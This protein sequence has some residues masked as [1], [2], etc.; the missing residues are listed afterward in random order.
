M[1][2]DRKKLQLLGYASG[3]AGADSGSS[4]GPFV[5]KESSYFSICKNNG[6][7]L[8]WLE[9]LQP[10]SGLSKV[11][12]VEQLCSKLAASTANLVKDNQFFTAFGGDHS[13]AIGTWGGAALALRNQGQLGL[14]W[15]DAHMDSHTPETSPSGNIHGMPVACLLG[16]GLPALVNIASFAPKIQPEHLCLIGVRSYES[17]EADL[18]KKLNVRIFYMEEVRQRGMK[19]V[20]QE[21][22]QIVKKGTAGFGISIDIDSIDPEDAPATGVAEP[23]GIPA[24]ALHDALTLLNNEPSLVGVEIAE[25]D[26]HRDKDH[27]TEKLI[28]RLINAIILGK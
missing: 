24:N 7:V 2:P 8:N 1:F 18:L 26:P 10:E 11:E 9:I 15:V 27:K 4:Q 22:L 23:N 20:M 5:L 14:I 3:I 6:I 19:A 21:A 16:C 28:P 12:I 17:G 25:F 13:C